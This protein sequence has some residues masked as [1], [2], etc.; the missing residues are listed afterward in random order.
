V[1]VR[2]P[3]AGANGRRPG[4]VRRGARGLGSDQLDEVD[5]RGRDASAAPA[6]AATD[7]GLVAG[8]D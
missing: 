5:A 6:E 7:A 8:S 3:D 1:P 2:L 4:V